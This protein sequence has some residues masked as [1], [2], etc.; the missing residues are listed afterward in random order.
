MH[1]RKVIQVKKNPKTHKFY[2]GKLLQLF[3]FF[4]LVHTPWDF[5][6]PTHLGDDVRHFFEVTC[7]E[8]EV[9][10]L[11]FQLVS[12]ILNATGARIDL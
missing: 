10:C 7:S 6:S 8:L 3:S 12:H 2:L 5:K 4:L 11:F 9:P 1:D